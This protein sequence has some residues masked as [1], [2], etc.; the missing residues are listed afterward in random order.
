M[1]GGARRSQGIPE[2]TA[3]DAKVVVAGD[4]RHNKGDD[5]ENVDSEFCPEFH[6]VP[7][8]EYGDR[9]LFIDQ[10]VENGDYDGQLGY[11]L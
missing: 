11:G 10:H 3:V 2:E 9:Q 5:N 7:I 1:D 6:R 8:G 4:Y